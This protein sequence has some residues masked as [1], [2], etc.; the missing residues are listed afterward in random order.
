M[1]PYVTTNE[2]SDMVEDLKMEG[3]EFV[4]GGR[5]GGDGG[6]WEDGVEDGVVGRAGVF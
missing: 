6:V 3:L 5:G 4:G 2:W 1:L